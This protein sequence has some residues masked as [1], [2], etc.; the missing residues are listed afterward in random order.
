MFYRVLISY[1]NPFPVYCKLLVVLKIPVAVLIV[2]YNFV[3][4]FKL[5]AVI[6]LLIGVPSLC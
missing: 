3:A 4:Y 1:G 6:M 2:Q 5:D